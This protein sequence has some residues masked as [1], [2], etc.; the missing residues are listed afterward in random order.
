MATIERRTTTAGTPVYRVRIRRRGLPTRS[1]TFADLQTARQWARATEAVVLTARGLPPAQRH[2]LAAAI[3][4]RFSE[5][6]EA[7]PSPQAPQSTAKIDGRTRRYVAV[8]FL[9]GALMLALEVIWFRFLL[10]T[11]DGTS[12][13]FAVMLAIVLGGI[14]IGGLI[15][16]R[17][18]ERDEHAYRWLRHVTA[19]SAALVVLTYSG[20]D[21][22][23]VHSAERDTTTSEFVF[24]SLFLMLPVSLLSGVAFTMVNRA[25]KDSFGASARTTGIATFFNTTGAMIGS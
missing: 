4:L 1:A 10:L 21:L 17:M 19:A 3:A 9:S 23:E 14:A 15:A 2:T 13:I 5:E 11:R 24:Y 20:F 22:F 18:F 7:T 25:V 12:L 6:A 8:A 16:G